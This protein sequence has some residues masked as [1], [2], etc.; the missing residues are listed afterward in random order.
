MEIMALQLAKLYRDNIWKMHGLPCHIMSNRGPEFAA[1]LMKSLCVMLGTKQ[2]LS[3][4]YHP[5]TDGH[6]E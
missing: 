3:T 4:A 6:V 2:N 5:Q 1:E